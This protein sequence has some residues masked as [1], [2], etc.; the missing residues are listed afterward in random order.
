[1]Y[2][3]HFKKSTALFYVLVHSAREDIRLDTWQK[4]NNSHSKIRL[5][6]FPFDKFN[7]RH[8]LASPGVNG[9]VVHIY[10]F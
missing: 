4:S 1:M 5:T 6:L 9:T 7:F 3:K 8:F 2:F 10:N